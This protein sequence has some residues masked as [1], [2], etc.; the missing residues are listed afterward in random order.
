MCHEKGENRRIAQTFLRKFDG[1]ARDQRID[2]PPS[3]VVVLS[4]MP[5]R[6]CG[7]SEA[8]GTGSGTCGK[9]RRG[10]YGRRRFWRGGEETGP[11]GRRALRYAEGRWG[12][13]T[14]VKCADFRQIFAVCKA[15]I[16][17]RT[18]VRQKF[19]TRQTAKLAGKMR[20]WAYA[21]RP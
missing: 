19:L 20:L 1:L 7:G 16:C 2:L 6:G 13:F 10:R 8:F 21:N 17:R 12:L 9:K 14:Q 4:K 3:F 11:R 18:D 15:K 5:F